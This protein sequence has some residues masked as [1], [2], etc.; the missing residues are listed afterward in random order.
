M[1][2]KAEWRQ[3]IWGAMQREGVVRFPGAHGRIPNFKGAEAA[4]ER[5]AQIPAWAQAASIKANPDSPQRPVRERA[6]REGKRV[7]MAVPRLR[8]EACF[9]ELDPNDF[10]PEELRWASTI[11]GSTELGRPRTLAEMPR[12]DLVV[13][14]SVVVDRNGRRIGKGGGY[15]DLEYALAREAGLIDSATPV[16]TTVHPLQVVAGPLPTEPHD[17]VLT[18]IVTPQEVLACR[19]RPAPPTGIDWSQLSREK[20]AAIPVLQAH[21]LKEEGGA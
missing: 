21:R 1:K 14:G 3:E 6:L 9:L 4:A 13:A 5:L 12:I 20:I 8:A 16:V 17:L 15:A 19:E 10:E 7:W 2:S 18:A 11:K